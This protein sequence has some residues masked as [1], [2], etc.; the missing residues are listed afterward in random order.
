MNELLHFHPSISSYNF[1][2]NKDKAGRLIKKLQ[3][4]FNLFTFT[5]IIRKLGSELIR[6]RVFYCTVFF[7]KPVVWFLKREILCNQQPL[8]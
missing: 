2:I 4:I 6:E 1:S 7:C 5:Y 8:C 3:K